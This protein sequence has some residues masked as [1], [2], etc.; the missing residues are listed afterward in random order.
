[1]KNKIAQFLSTTPLDARVYILASFINSSG[2]ALM[3]PLITLYVSTELGRSYGEAGMV[4]LLQAFFGII[5]EIVGGALYYK[6]GPRQLI[7][8]STLLSGIA[9]FSV[10]FVDNWYVYIGLM[11]MMGFV[12]GITMPGVNAYIGFRWASYRKSLF[13]TIY[14]F[15]NLGLAFGAAVGGVLASISFDLTYSVTGVITILFAFFLSSF[16]KEDVTVRTSDLSKVKYDSSLTLLKDYKVYLFLAIGAV[17]YWITFNFWGTGAG[18]YLVE[19]GYDISLYSLLWTIN[20]FVILFGQPLLVF[21]KNTIAKSITRQIVLSSVFCFIGYFFLFHFNE[22][23]SYFIV[24]MVICTLGEML[25]LPA[26]PLFFSEYTGEK[27][28]FYMGL[29]GSF[30]NAGRMV[31]PLII[32]NLL[33]GWGI[34]LTMLFIIVCSVVSIAFFVIHLYVFKPKEHM[35]VDLVMDEK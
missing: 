4:L 18:P 22:N 23:Y 11:C 2:K 9:I 13:N 35:H 3:W 25:L 24:A 33:D 16:M 14:V 32:G 28:P 27:A 20:G 6:V 5:G 21:L 15:N 10:I 19:L 31:G 1:M 12:N 34:S 26:I 8:S 30:S 7:F 29:A 17:F